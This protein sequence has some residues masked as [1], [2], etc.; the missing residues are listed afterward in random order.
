MTPAL[1]LFAW[2]AVQS[3]PVQKTPAASACSA[4][5]Y[6]QFDFWIGEWDVVTPDGRTAGRNSIT[7]EF[8]GCVLQERWRGAGGTEGGSFNIYNPVSRTWHQ[9]WVDSTGLLL[10]LTG[11]FQNDA[12]RMTGLGV[13]PKGSSLN[14]ITWRP[15]EDGQVRQIWETS[16]DDGRTWKVIFEGRYK[17]RAAE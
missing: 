17:K 11:A 14:R 1:V 15:V 5:E 2:W 16:P 13:G 3:A 7:R 4:A 9:T 10:T 12:M 8:G 6:R